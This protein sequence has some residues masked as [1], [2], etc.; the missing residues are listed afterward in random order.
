M[1]TCFLAGRYWKF[2]H[3]N[4]IFLAVERY[5]LTKAKLDKVQQPA[6]VNELDAELLGSDENVDDKAKRNEQ[7][8]EADLLSS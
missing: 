6:A 4:V 2:K 8:K 7:M 1:F 3:Y 5:K